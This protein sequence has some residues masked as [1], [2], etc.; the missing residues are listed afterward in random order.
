MY[1]NK[2]MHTHTYNEQMGIYL[3]FHKL[4][5]AEFLCYYSDSTIIMLGTLQMSP[6]MRSLPWRAYN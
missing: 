3:V 2:Y 4:F 5:F 1:T 6:K